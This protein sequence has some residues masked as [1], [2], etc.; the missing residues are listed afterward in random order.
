M[1]PV[2]EITKL[3]WDYGKVLKLKKKVNKLVLK[4]KYLNIEEQV[5]E[6][7]SNLRNRNK[8]EFKI[9]QL[10]MLGLVMDLC[11]ISEETKK[12]LFVKNNKKEV[13]L[14][15]KRNEKKKSKLK[16]KLGKLTSLENLQEINSDGEKETEF[17]SSHESKE[18]GSSSQLHRILNAEK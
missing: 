4:S 16:R 6:V 8:F 11:G 2:N 1:V 13:Q 5:F 14:R 12:L 17:E 3:D 18:G 7:L 9:S 10:L 15:A